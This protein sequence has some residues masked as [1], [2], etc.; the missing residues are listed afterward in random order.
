MVTTNRV[1]PAIKPINHLILV[2]DP[3]TQARITHIIRTQFDYEILLKRYEL[4]AIRDEIARGEEQLARLTHLLINGEMPVAT[5]LRVVP[6][7]VLPSRPSTPLRNSPAPQP[8]PQP[9][10]PPPPRVSQSG[11]PVR[12][13][14]RERRAALVIEKTLF[15]KRDDGVFV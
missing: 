9:I 2:L 5:P 12:A 10:A 11:R 14:A 7:R 6:T 4:K 3:E 1:S 8:Q 13:V 15:A